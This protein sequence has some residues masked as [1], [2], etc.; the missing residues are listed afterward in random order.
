MYNTKS[1]IFF[2]LVALFLSSCASHKDMIL[3]RK[4]DEKP[5]EIKLPAQQDIKQQQ[6]E[7]KL[8]YNDVIGI[9]VSAPNSEL[10]APY[11]F[12]SP[13]MFGQAQ[14]VNSVSAFL[15][16]KEGNLEIPNI[17][18]IHAIGM[19][20]SELRDSIKVRVSQLIINPSVNVRLLNFK[21]TIL[22]EVTKP[23]VVEIQNEQV[24]ILEAIGRAGDIT[25]YGDRQHVKV[26][27]EQ[28]G[29]REFAELDLK[30]PD[31]FKSPYYYLRQ[32]DVIYIEPKNTKVAQIEQPINRYLG[33]VQVT[34]TF[35]SLIIALTK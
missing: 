7:L 30:S 11:N 23:G 19:T 12:I 31:I 6:I 27:R 1:I 35:L 22:G 15:I 34:L 29:I 16:N 24:S 3:F 9:L 10:A 2:M 13:Q 28:N 8:Q 14:A 18:T 4:G 33:P 5:E 21:V 20:V 17:G 32:N 25:P 26:I